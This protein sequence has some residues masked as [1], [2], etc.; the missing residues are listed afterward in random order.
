M[1]RNTKRVDLAKLFTWKH[2][3]DI[4]DENGDVV[5]TVYQR[6]VN[7]Q[8]ME[9]ARL[10][11]IK[12]S[13]K[14][15]LALRDSTTPEYASLMEALEVYDKDQMIGAILLAKLSESLREARRKVNLPL[16]K[17][18]GDSL[19]DNEL[20]EKELDEYESKANELIQA[21]LATINDA[22]TKQLQE[23]P[24]EEL[25]EICRKSLENNICSSVANEY[26]LMWQ[27]Y[28]GTYVDEALEE[29]YFNSFEEFN[30]LPAPVKQQLINGYNKLSID[31]EKLKNWQ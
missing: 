24:I 10:E 21:E 23:L 20:Y 22:L 30:N 11:A 9:R 3:L 19:E 17:P 1:R 28:L 14:T 26:M 4:L 27:V 31:A 5:T 8:D 6:V 12:Q 7:D 16:P 2:T 15:R 13:R 29:L 25:R 18:R